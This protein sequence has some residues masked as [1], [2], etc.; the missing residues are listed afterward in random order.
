[1]KEKQSE[2]L[3]IILE[4]R[5]SSRWRGEKEGKIPY[6]LLFEFIKCPLILDLWRLVRDLSDIG[7]WCLGKLKGESI[8]V[9]IRWLGGSASVHNCDLSTSF[10][11]WCLIGIRSMIASIPSKGDILKAPSIQMVALLCI[12]LRIFSGYKRGAQL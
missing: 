11:R 3:S 6:D 2:K 7:C 8:S 9:Q 5:E 4:P 12:L 10:W 1:M